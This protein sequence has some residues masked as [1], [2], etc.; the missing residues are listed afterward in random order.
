MPVFTTL[1]LFPK[2]IQYLWVRLLQG[3]LIKREFYVKRCVAIAGDKLQIKDAEL[4]INDKLVPM[5]KH[6]QH[7]YT[8]VVKGQ[9]SIIIL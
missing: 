7:F 3:L 2:E 9:I 4:Y 5:P 6:A 8:V 1:I